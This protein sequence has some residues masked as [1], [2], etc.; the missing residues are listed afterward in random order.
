M[1]LLRG[2]EVAAPSRI[3]EAGPIDETLLDLRNELVGLANVVG[4]Y[5]L[6]GWEPGTNEHGTFY[7]HPPLNGEGVYP[8]F[9]QITTDSSEELWVQVVQRRVREGGYTELVR[10]HSLRP[11]IFPTFRDS[12]TRVHEGAEL[13]KRGEYITEHRSHQRGFTYQDAEYL[14]SLRQILVGARRRSD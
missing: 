8:A 10:C 9:I 5:A 13:D 11:L 3:P 12:Y 7:R 1:H 14:W 2:A 6:E 4:C